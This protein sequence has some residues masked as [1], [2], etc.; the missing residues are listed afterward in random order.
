VHLLSLVPL[1]V[2]LVIAVVGV[3]G[4]TERLPRNRFGGVRTPAAMRTDRTFQVANKVAGLPI[5]VAGAV[6]VLG[7][8]VGVFAANLVIGM[9]GFVGM[10]G[11][12]VAGG[13]LGHRAAEAMPVEEQEPELPA[14]CRGCACGGCDLAKSVGANVTGVGG[15]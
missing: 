13:M 1:V 15:Q 14:G 11:I 6:G 3:L 12:A 8:L 9:I 10:V 5:A 4:L 7:G 2:G